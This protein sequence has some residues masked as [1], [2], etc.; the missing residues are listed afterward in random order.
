MSILDKILE[1]IPEPRSE[2]KPHA[3]RIS[4]VQIPVDK[5]GAIIGPGGKTIRSIQ[6]ETGTKIDIGEDGSVFIAATDGESA[7]LA[8]E[9]VESLIEVPAVMTHVS[10]QGSNLEVDPGL[11]RLSV[12][13]ENVD[14][15]LADM[16]EAV[17]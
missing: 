7:R 10:T 3:P 2:L 9:R 4:V 14:D 11:V 17:R 12:G 5:I 6:E 16:E 13:I 8:V 15:L 1:V